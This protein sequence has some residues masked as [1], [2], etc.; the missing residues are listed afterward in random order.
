MS[1]VHAMVA[2]PTAQPTSCCAWMLVAPSVENI[3]STPDHSGGCSVAGIDA[4]LMNHWAGM[5]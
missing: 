5:M 2:A 1:P 4:P 3:D